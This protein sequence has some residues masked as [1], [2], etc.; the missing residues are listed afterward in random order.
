MGFHLLYD[1]SP[2]HAPVA[3]SLCVDGVPTIKLLSAGVTANLS[4]DCEAAGIV[5]S[6]SSIGIHS[7]EAKEHLV[8]FIGDNCPGMQE[9]SG[10][11]IETVKKWLG[12]L[13]TV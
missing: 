8:S 3:I 13:G 6:L 5:A 4:A 11:T 10:G 2:R 7:K 1:T 12:C 9:D